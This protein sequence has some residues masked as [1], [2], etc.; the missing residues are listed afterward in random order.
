MNIKAHA[1]WMIAFASSPAYSNEILLGNF[2]HEFT[3]TSKDIVWTIKAAGEKFDITYHGDNT[4]D[5]L[6]PLSSKAV[7]SLWQKLHWPDETMS[8]AS[9]LGN[10]EDTFCHVP[11]EQ[12]AN[13]DWLMDYKSDFFYYSVM[14]GIMQI[15]KMGQ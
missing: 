2:G 12:R 4:K 7:R 3:R 6:R 13:I 1:L 10:E 14:G 8:S 5:R 9:C 15:H 11:K